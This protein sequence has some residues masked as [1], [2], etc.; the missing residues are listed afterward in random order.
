MPQELF[1]FLAIGNGGE[2]VDRERVVCGECLGRGRIYQAL[3]GNWH[4]SKL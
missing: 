2:I 3:L 1:L 4:V